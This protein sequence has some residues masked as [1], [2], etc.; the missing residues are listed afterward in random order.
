MHTFK[1]SKREDNK[2][3]KRNTK[4]MREL[5]RDHEKVELLFTKEIQNLK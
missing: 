5:R 1:L 4:E 2:K 3:E